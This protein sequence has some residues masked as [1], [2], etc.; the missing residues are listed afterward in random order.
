MDRMKAQA[1]R[2][3]TRVVSERIKS[4]DLSE[5]PFVLSPNYSEPVKALSVIVAT[6]AMAKW[7]GLHN[8]LRLAKAGGGVS[9]CAVCAKDAR[10]WVRRECPARARACLPAISHTATR[11]SR[12]ASPS[13]SDSTVCSLRWFVAL[14]TT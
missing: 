8:E 9:A 5:H 4:V 12:L 14:E 6:G 3:G 1:V 11:S 13:Q 7:I 10:L 2:Y